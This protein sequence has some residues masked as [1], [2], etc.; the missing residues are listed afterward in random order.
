[1][2]SKSHSTSSIVEASATCPSPVM[3]MSKRTT[4]PGRTES[5]GSAL[6]PP[7]VMDV[8]RPYPVLA[9]HCFPP[10]PVVSAFTSPASLGDRTIESRQRAAPVL[11]AWI[12][13]SCQGADRYDRTTLTDMSPRPPCGAS[14]S[15]GTEARRGHEACTEGPAR[16]H[17]RRARSGGCRLCKHRLSAACGESGSRRADAGSRRADAGPPWR[18][19]EAHRKDRRGDARPAG[20]LHAPVLEPVHGDVRRP[21]R[22]HEGRRSR[23]LQ[24]RAGPRREDAY[25]YE[26]REDLDV[27]D[28]QGS[29]VLERQGGHDRRRRRLPAAGSSRSR[30]RRRA[31]STPASSART[32][33]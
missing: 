4:S 33:A 13:L 21:A 10:R 32:P 31:V 1:M 9:P 23:G 28:P 8:R 7:V 15:S 26:R 25:P 30:A 29:Q 20:E 19:H 3:G 14:G 5:A 2:V 17:G 27:Q 16:A 6:A 12:L 11:E 24:R 18:N 22:V